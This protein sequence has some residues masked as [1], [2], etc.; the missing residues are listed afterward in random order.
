MEA[1]QDENPTV[2]FNNLP[3]K[4]KAFHDSD[5]ES[6]DSEM[7]V[8]GVK[9]SSMRWGANGKD[10]EDA[11]RLGKRQSAALPQATRRSTRYNSRL[12]STE[13]ETHELPDNPVKERSSR[14][15]RSR[16]VANA[17]AVRTGKPAASSQ[18]SQDDDFDELAKGDADFIPVV[19]S[20]LQ[21]GK[22]SRKR[23]RARG[24]PPGRAY[25]EQSIEFEV[26]RR[27]ARTNKNTRSMAE[28][29]MVDDES[30]YADEEKTL[31]GPKVISVKEVFQPVEESDFKDVHCQT[32]DTCGQG[33]TP[34][35]GPLIYCQGCSLAFHK[36]CLGYRSTRD[37]T[38]TK[39]GI[40]NFV[41]QCR[42]CV[43]SFRA[44][45]KTAPRLD[46]CQ[47]CQEPGRACHPFSQKQTAK[48]EEKARRDNGGVDPITPV[49]PGLINEAGSVLF[50]CLAC[51]RAFHFEHLPPP[52]DTW[53]DPDFGDVRAERLAEYSIEW[54]CRD[55]F[56]DGNRKVGELVAWR[57]TDAQ[58][59]V[60]D[61]T[62]F[63]FSDDSKEYLVRWESMSHA[64]CVWKPGAWVWGVVNP[65]MRS[66][67]PK[68]NNDANLLPQFDAKAAIPE[69][70]LLAD[71]ILAVRYQHV[72]GASSK[73][74]SKQADIDRIDEVEAI[75]VKFQGLGYDEA[76]W[77]EPP[78]RD[79]GNL[80]TAFSSAYLEFLNGKHFKTEAH[81]RMQERIDKFHAKVKF[82]EL[83][84]Q[85]AGL[86]RGKL[87]EYQ[88]QGLNWLLFKFYKLQ[89][90]VLADEMGLGKTIQVIGLLAHVVLESPKCWP[91]LVV[92]P[93]ST[94]PNWR[95]EIK[96]W[97]PDL[98]VVTYHG[99]KIPQQLAYEHELFPNQSK[100]IKAHV[101]I[102]SYDSAQ[103]P[104]TRRLFKPV[105]WAGLIVD[106]GQRLKNDQNILYGA[107]R[108][109]KID[110]RLLLTGTPLQNNK[111]EL[112]NLL[113]FVDASRNAAELDEEYSEITNENLPVLH[114]LIR[115]YFLR[116]TKADVLRAILPP[117]ARS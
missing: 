94:C 106:E 15:L 25:R 68:R 59:Y 99:G 47:S 50:R 14:R 6:D 112:F 44:K 60:E 52:S 83:E 35:K 65:R 117:W 23:K 73:P 34:N 107:L 11:M 90:V 46:T 29:S 42:C 40:D 87:M 89:S 115:P 17:P 96:T 116:R 58:S 48:Q 4:R 69:E 18:Q 13:D 53:V 31:G 102:M 43:N 55:C 98:R 5:Y 75:R 67:F 93:N 10:K 51:R 114:E 72:V 100:D 108:A 41:L 113:Q 33:P 26:A 110:F 76:V 101:V 86:Q 16:L 79:S 97:A 82:Q 39:V 81:V 62:Y 24:R 64:H 20:D 28:A 37:H 85:P 71:V 78:C 63:D 3:R 80:W 56:K 95:R 84:Q 21:V 49:D 66:A 38:V 7:D 1:F 19:R 45:D 36:A 111:R 54:K 77:D 8:D 2:G 109:M 88:L 32:C 57:P 105:R 103:D 61:Q 9:A 104:E 70:F 91:F 30:I 74:T 92:V 12:M 22:S 27:S